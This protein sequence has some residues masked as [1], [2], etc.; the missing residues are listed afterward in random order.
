MPGLPRS[1]IR[2]G[3]AADGPRE[4]AALGSPEYEELAKHYQANSTLGPGP[5]TY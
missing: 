5:Y 3:L 2:P 4:L 1:R